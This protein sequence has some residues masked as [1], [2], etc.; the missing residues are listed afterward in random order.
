LINPCRTPA[1]HPDLWH[2]ARRIY[3]SLANLS[4]SDSLPSRNK[5]IYIQRTK[6]NSKNQG[7]LILN[8]EP[9]IEI[10]R[11]YATKASLKFILYDHSQ[12]QGNIVDQIQLFHQARVII[13][14]HGG[15]QS[16][17]NFAQPGTT[18]IEIMPYRS[19]QST[20]PVVCKLSHP[21]ELKPCVGYIY[22]TQSQ[23]LNHSYWILPTPI[24]S[25]RNLNVNLTR[26][27]RLFDSLT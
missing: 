27:K 16:N 22:Y 21:N 20:V 26:V 19:E 23:L 24:D 10:L 13:G 12:Q 15:A 6:S 3:W 9:F 14:T 17:M 2:N 5:L 1:T 25:G 4:Q 18:I 8:E 11:Q 7:R